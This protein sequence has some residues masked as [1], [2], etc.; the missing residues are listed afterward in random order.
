MVLSEILNLWM[1]VFFRA[2]LILRILLIFRAMERI[3]TRPA[4]LLAPSRRLTTIKYTSKMQMEITT[5][6]LYRSIMCTIKD[7][8][9]RLTTVLMLVSSAFPPSKPLSS[10]LPISLQQWSQQT[11]TPRAPL[12]TTLSFWPSLAWVSWFFSFWISIGTSST[13][14]MKITIL[15]IVAKLS[16]CF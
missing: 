13:I 11:Q 5:K 8:H 16:F 12:S 1:A 6:Y 7:S 2:T 3:S 10:L 4:P 15:T 14:L 9:L